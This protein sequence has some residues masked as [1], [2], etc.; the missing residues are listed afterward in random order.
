M[1]AK[2]GS[3]EPG[4]T[5]GVTVAMCALSWL[6]ELWDRLGSLG[7]MDST[8]SSARSKQQVKHLLQWGHYF[9]LAVV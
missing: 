7:A 5:E 8:A 9:T 6:W 3:F 2:V 4:R 1:A